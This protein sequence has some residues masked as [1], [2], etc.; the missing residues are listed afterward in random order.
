MRLNIDKLMIGFVM[1]LAVCLYTPTLL[2]DYKANS[3]TNEKVTEVLAEAPVPAKTTES[4]VLAAV[5][6]QES[7]GEAV[8]AVE[9][10]DVIG[11]D[12]TNTMTVDAGKIKPKFQT[13]INMTNMIEET[14]VA[15]SG[16]LQ[17]MVEAQ[18]N[19]V[20]SEFIAHVKTLPVEIKPSLMARD[21]ENKVKAVRDNYDEFLNVVETYYADKAAIKTA[22]SVQTVQYVPTYTN[23]TGDG[24]LTASKGVNYGPSGKETY[25]NL[26]MNGVVNIMQ[27]MGYNEQYWVREDGVKMYGDY[28]MV[29]ADLNTHPRGS[30]VESSLGTAIVVDTGGF[31]SSN[32]DQLD[33][34]TAW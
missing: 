20:Y 31:A 28:V 1:I 32:P 18:K 4:V 30:I 11:N 25:Y 26:N 24:K 22:Q 10:I 6:T 8:A 9:V 16:M 15:E 7:I 29:A 5:T 17:S 12:I 33:I 34:A 21:E 2:E 23:V 14:S 19:P 13:Q 3:T 27:S